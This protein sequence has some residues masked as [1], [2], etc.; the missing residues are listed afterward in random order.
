MEGLV[1][2]FGLDWRLLII[3]A[4]NFTVLLTGLTY[5]LYTPVMQMIA[6]RRE[7]V[8]EGVRSAQEADR[9]LA[10]SKKQGEGI[11]GE[12]ARE[13]EGLVAAARA[14]ADERGQELVREAERKAHAV[15][16]DAN[17]RAEE[18]TR[19]ALMESEKEITR[20]AVLAAEKIL[21]KEA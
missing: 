15:I 11:V 21:R 13:A 4:V 18:A 12:A 20:A 7:M 1:T 16:A 3:Q 9:V 19:L 6:K 2:A 5:F 8:A 14:R 10:D 17:A